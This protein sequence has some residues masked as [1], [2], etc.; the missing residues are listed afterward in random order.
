MSSNI[1]LNVL[2][3][4]LDSEDPRHTPIYDQPKIIKHLLKSEKVKQLA[5]HI[6]LNGVNPLDSIGVL[7]DE[8]ANYIS[9]EGNRRLC[10][11]LLLNDPEKAPAGEIQYFKKLAENST[12]VPSS[13]NCI[14]FDSLDE[15]K[16]WMGVRHDG[17][18]D[19]VGI[20]SWDPDQKTRNKARTN[21]KDQNALALELIDYATA[22]QYLPEARTERILTT[23]ARYLGNPFVRETFGIISPR[24]EHDVKIDVPCEA[25]DGIIKRFSSDLISNTVVHSRSRREDWINYAKSLIEEG[26]APKEKV[27]A[28]LLSECLIQEK[29]FKRGEKN[30]YIAN[31]KRGSNGSGGARSL[32]SLDGPKSGTIKHPDTRKYIVPNDFEVAI[33][34]QILRRVFQE[35]REIDVD[36]KPLAVSQV[37]RAFLENLYILFYERI[38]GSYSHQ[39]IHVL[40]GNVITE[41]GKNS[42]LTKSEKNA[43]GA[44]KRVQSNENNVLSPKTLGAN[45]HAG[46]YPDSIQLKRE[47]DN[48]SAL[49]KYMLKRIA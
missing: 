20:R 37:V 18:Q 49:I 36:D 29:R 32:G 39:R 17:E 23:A 47:F 16:I 30:S 1:L 2:D 19:G 15:A 46:I 6:S 38:T 8:E 35:M 48:I 26:I 3:V 22:R 24:S 27:G 45:A 34:N 43:L 11:L 10:A 21:R 14:L 25:F 7:K 12:I 4:Y 40:L 41:V 31:G 28:Q 13:I 42:D 44:L 9:V 33:T 5:R